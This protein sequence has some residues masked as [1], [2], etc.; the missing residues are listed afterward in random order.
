MKYFSEKATFLQAGLI[1]KL[2]DEL[3]ENLS[4]NFK[5][6]LS[7]GRFVAFIFDTKESECFSRELGKWCEKNHFFK[8]VKLK[9]TRVKN[10]DISEV[11]NFIFVDCTFNKS[12]KDTIGVM[13]DI[14]LSD[15][16]LVGLI[17]PS[18]YTLNSGCRLYKNVKYD[19]I[20]THKP[21]IGI[22]LND[23]LD[24][25]R[26]LCVLNNEYTDDF[27]L[28]REEDLKKLIVLR[29]RNTHKGDYCSTSIVGGSKEYTGA[30]LLSY[31]S[32]TSLKLGSGFSYLVV[33]ES[34]RDIYA[35]KQPQ[36]IV[37]TLDDRDGNYIFSKEKLDD[38]IEFSDVI[39]FGM[40]AGVSK[41][42]YKIIS[43][44]IL[45][46]KGRLIIDADGLNS[47][48]KY[49][50]EILKK[51]KG[52]I[53]LTPH[54]KEFSRLAG[55]RVDEIVKNG[56]EIAETFADEFKIVLLVKSASS[57]I[58]DGKNLCVNTSG[59]AGLAKAGSGDLLSGIIGG[60][61]SNKKI[62][63]FDC[64]A[65]GSYLLGRL[66]EDAGKK[67]FVDSLTYDNIVS[68]I[69]ETLLNLSLKYKND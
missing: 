9:R 28:V 38:L 4:R 65:T 43:Y 47:L 11:E 63:T 12:N 46:F 53:I 48:A 18:G 36:A 19:I 14:S 32:L 44:L 41:N 25:Y 57:I 26:Y 15:C 67:F 20:I 37:K 35:L 1:E 42:I 33:P 24:S 51:H 66:A 55:V 60:I 8:N 69:G 23:C 2:V 17:Y 22:Y 56:V 31:L 34:A 39:V 27:H 52:E 7:G 62:S 54:V 3:G 45:K 13:S 64:A 40:G 61:S 10:I 5:N 21:N 29:D 50:V 16:I 68:Q 30:P 49:G 59:N 6:I 58:T